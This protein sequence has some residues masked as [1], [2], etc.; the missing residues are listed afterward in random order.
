MR[1]RPAELYAYGDE[2]PANNFY[3]TTF[4]VAEVQEFANWVFSYL[5]N[6]EFLVMGDMSSPLRAWDFSI[7]IALCRIEDNQEDTSKGKGR[8]VERDMFRIIRRSDL[9]MRERLDKYKDVLGACRL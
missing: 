9:R 7:C 5:P 6:L 3:R 2:D 4:L 8:E 1:N